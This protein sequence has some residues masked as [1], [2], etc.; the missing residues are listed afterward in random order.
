M[1]KYLILATLVLVIII[2]VQIANIT[3]L[4]ED[5]RGEKEPS[6]PNRKDNK[7]NGVLMMVFLIG[8]LFFMYWQMVKYKKDLL[9]VS[10]SEHGVGVDKLLDLNF[11]IIGAVFLLT[12]VLLFWYAYKYKGKKDQKAE[13]YPENHR[14]ETI[15]TVIPAIVLMVVIVLGLKTWSGIT[16]PAPADAM[17]VELYAKQFDFTVRY[18]GADKNLGSSFFKL[19]TDENVLGL[20]TNDVKN[21]DDVVAKEI[22]LPVNRPVDFTFHS[23][24]VIHSAYMPH[25]RVQ[26]NCVPGMDTKF[27][28]KPTITT[29]KMREL[30]HDENF[31][32]VL[33]CNKV[34]GVAHFNMKMTI[35]VETE[36]EFNKWLASQKT[37]AQSRMKASEAP[38]QSAAADSAKASASNSG[39][40]HSIL[41]IN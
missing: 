38:Q 32:Y 3:G 6:K 20:D 8:E 34:C 1:L 2:C 24:D 28:F 10:A 18:P 4:L 41:S 25:F 31:E 27:H 26:M 36:E 14:L 13:F 23:R 30:N 7:W 40:Q 17:N 39:K 22:H 21:S 15:W 29:A 11:L 19:I 35:V 33:L 9:P 12:Q 16:A 5:I 37:F